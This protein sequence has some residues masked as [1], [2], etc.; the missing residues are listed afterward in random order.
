MLKKVLK[1]K[2]ILIKLLMVIV[3]FIGLQTQN[4][5]N[6]QDTNQDKC[7]LTLDEYAEIYEKNFK[8]NLIEFLSPVKLDSFG[9]IGL[10]DLWARLDNVAIR[11]N[12]APK[13]I[14]YIVV[15]GGKVTKFGELKERPKPILFYLERTH[16]MDIQRIKIVE[17]GFREK[18]EIELWESRTKKMSP[19]LFPTISPEKVIFKGKMKPLPIYY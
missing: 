14:L 4:F 18:F 19:P 9:E 1:T 7:D 3:F 5:I 11:M 13:V 15:Y 8:V 17:G 16:K 6:A 12:N 10:D 2:K